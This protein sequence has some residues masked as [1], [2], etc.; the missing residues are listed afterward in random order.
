MGTRRKL[1]R[2][3]TKKSRGGA[4][5]GFVA[6][7]IVNEG[8]KRKKEKFERLSREE[9]KAVMETEQFLAKYRREHR[10]DPSPEY[11]AVIDQVSGL[12]KSLT[13]SLEETLNFAGELIGPAA[14]DSARELEYAV[15]SAKRSRAN[16]NGLNHNPGKINP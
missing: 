1:A 10:D 14:E 2:R 3:K 11:A 8:N 7:H 4:A 5:A 6:S 16:G 9:Q 12:L 13:K 15:P